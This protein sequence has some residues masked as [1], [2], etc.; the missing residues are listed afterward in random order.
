[1]FVGGF[2]VVW[3]AIGFGTMSEKE[4]GTCVGQPQSNL[5]WNVEN[6]VANWVS[7]FNRKYAEDR[8]YAFTGERTYLT[9]INA[10]DT[11]IKYYDSITGKQLFEGPKSRS[12]QDFL[13]EAQPS[14]WPSFRGDEV[15]WEY[16]K[17]HWDGEI[18]SVD[19]THLG[20]NLPDELGN[21]YCI[22]LSSIAGLPA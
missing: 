19:G 12:I 3:E 8:S 4:N 6:D 1:M 20:H 18:Y 16:V 11:D 22:N 17:E 5:R 14:G 7:C 10:S 13:D 2:F 9:W 21:R 15:N